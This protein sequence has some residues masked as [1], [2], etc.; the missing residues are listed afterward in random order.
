MTKGADGLRLPR[1]SLFGW[2]M[3]TDP[4]A[5]PV[6]AILLAL[7]LAATMFLTT[8]KLGRAMCAVRDSEHAAAASG[9]DVRATKVL[10]FAI[11][12]VYAG[13]AGGMF[14]IYQSYINPNESLGFNYIVL[15]LSMIVVGGLGT[16]PG[17]LIG[18]AILG[19]LPEVLRTTMRNLLVWQEFVYGLILILAMMFMPRGIWGLI[20]TRRRGRRS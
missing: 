7:M 4:T 1:P 3:G 6:N 5:F 19:V 10:A 17:V 2:D 8:S 14:T 18:V 20:H 11:S 15:V 16:I 9:I 13:V 12:A